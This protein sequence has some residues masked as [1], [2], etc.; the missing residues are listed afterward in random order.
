[1]QAGAVNN[2]RCAMTNINWIVD[3]PTLEKEHGMK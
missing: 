3:G 2:N 1:L